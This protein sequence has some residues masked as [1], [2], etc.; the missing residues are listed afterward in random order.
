MAAPAAFAAPPIFSD[1]FTN[2]NNWT[3]T[4]ITLDNTI[5]SPTLPSARAQVTDQSASA[6]VTLGTTT[7]TPCMSMNV[8]LSAG[9]GVDLFR[10]RTAANGPIIKAFVAANGTLQMRSDFGS[11]T[12]TTTT[13]MGTGWHNV[14]LCGTVGSATGWNLYRDGT[15]IVTNWVA[16]TGTTPV[17]RIQ[18]GDTA[19]KT[20]TA[21]FDHVVLDTA[22]G[23]DVSGDLI[24]PS[25]PGRPAGT[26]PSAGTIQISWAASTDPAPAS[27]PITYRIYRD[28]GLTSVGSSTTTSFTDTGAALVAGSTHTY[29]VDAVDAATN[30]SA[31]SQASLSITV[32][33]ATDNIAPSVPGRPAG[34]SPSAGTIQISWAA[35][36]DPAPASLPITYRIYRDN[37]L[38]SV[39]SSTTTSFTDTGAAL[40]AGST[41]TYTVDAVDAATNASAKSQASLSITVATAGGAGTQPVPGHTRLAYDVPRTNIPLITTGEITDLEYIGNRVFVAGSF[42]SIRNNTAGNTTSYNQPSLAAF[43]IDTGLV[44]ANFRP[45]FGGGGVTEVE[46]SPDGTKLFVV[47]RFNTVNG[48]TKRKV[49]SLNP[50]TGAVNTGF[51]ADANAAAT[52]VEASNTTVYIGGQFTTINGAGRVSLAAVNS[53]T[54]ANITGFINNLAGGVGVNGD[55]S[56]QALVLTHDGTK[57]LVVHTGSTIAGQT[58]Y[59]MGLIDTQTN[60]LLPWRSHLWDDNLQFVGGIT[61]IY[62]GAIAPNDQYFVVS[63]GSGGDR[64]PI[65]DTAVAYPIAGGDNVQPLWI[66]R[67]F[68][69]VYSVAISEVA[70]YLGGH[71]NYMESPT[72]PDPWPGLDNVGYGRGQG[73]AGYGLGDA[74][75]IRDHVGAVSPV[76]GKALNGFNPGSNSFEGNKAMLVM[77]RGVIA[78]G[79]ATTQGGYNVGRIAFYDFNSIPRSARTRR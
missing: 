45:T 27:L 7:M 12:R 71:M 63:S 65:S 69:S 70:V 8:N 24:A 6:F 76:D 60:Q 51:T 25:V 41:H 36:T 9:S 53:T 39:G 74:I 56:V 50:T 44:D 34:T 16:D 55:L 77:P 54:G 1:E 28:N 43:N 19:A 61:R 35:S 32:A 11:T 48:V 10:L 62:A 59:G 13:A 37:G 4:R 58:R 38:T 49:A 22:V 72:A 29:T 79:D 42:S 47:G 66:S 26:S 3:A 30:A 2:L 64:P 15:Q 21:N 68:D 20:F 78:G 57:L 5:G 73:L 17:G 67:C 75:V 46:A 52:S 23:D 33:T 31:K 18:I 40:V 14:E